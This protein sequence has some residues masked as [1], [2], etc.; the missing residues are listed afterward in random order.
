[1][2]SSLHGHQNCRLECY[3]ILRF[4]PPTTNQHTQ[5]T[6]THTWTTDIIN[7]LPRWGEKS[8]FGLLGSNKK[9]KK[10]KKKRKGGNS[11][12]FSFTYQQKNGIFTRKKA[13]IC[14]IDCFLSVA[15]I[16][17]G[18]KKKHSDDD[19]V[20]CVFVTRKN[21]E[22]FFVC[23]TFFGFRLLRLPPR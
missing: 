22:L 13:K 12:S 8:L 1:M 6:D 9:K 20:F 23:G 10:K 11:F 17:K 2:T 7:L 16:R 14:Q 18:E 19:E 21:G 5:H 3:G 15:P 4:P